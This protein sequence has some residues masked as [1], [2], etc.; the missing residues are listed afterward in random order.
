MGNRIGTIDCKK[1]TLTFKRD[2]LLYDIRNYTYIEGEAPKSSKSDAAN[3]SHDR[4]P[5][6]AAGD[7]G[8]VDRVTRVLDLAFAECV[9][10]CYPY[11]KAE[12]P[13]VMMMDD[14]LQEVNYTM[15]MHLPKDFSQTTVNLIEKSIHELLVCKVVADWMSINKPD[16]FANWQSKA[17]DAEKS[18]T[19]NLNARIGPVRRKMRPF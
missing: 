6:Q 12:L 5:V 2:E 15:Q 3:E 7:E 17:N 14:A 8:N 13:D 11:T 18:V 4:H 19:K 9:E 1:V 16:S 10:L